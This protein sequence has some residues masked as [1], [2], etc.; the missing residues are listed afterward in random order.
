[1]ES[2]N[3]IHP[4]KVNI[5]GLLFQVVSYASLS[6]AQALNVARHFYRTHRIKKKDKGKLYTVVTVI[7]KDSA[8]MW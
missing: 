3:V 6:D 4:K 8:S 1:M 2:P 5:N 7:D